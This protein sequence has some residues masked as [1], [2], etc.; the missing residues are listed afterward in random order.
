M[1]EILAQITP[2][3]RQLGFKGS[4]QNYRKEMPEA[5]MVIN[6]QK[7]TGGEQ[8]YVNLGVQPL[9]VPSE[10]SEVPAPKN[11]KEYECIFR[12]RLDTPPQMSGWPYDLS[13]VQLEELESKLIAAYENYLSPLAQVPGPITELTPEQF[14]TQGD[15]SIFGGPR[16]LYAL[17]FARIALARGHHARAK[18]FAELGLADCPPLASGLRFKLKKALDLAK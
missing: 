6:F 10:S 8:F 16:P 1:K 5:V 11:I 17:H 4:G 9:F 15:E 2:L 12:R 14:K 3:L 13:D 7:S 18:A